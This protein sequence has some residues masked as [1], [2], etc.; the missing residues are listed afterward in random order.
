MRLTHPKGIAGEEKA[1]RYLKKHHWNI[2]KR[3]WHCRFGEIDIIASKN[4]LLVFFEVRYRSSSTF[5]GAAESITLSKLEKL[6]K[7]VNFYLTMYPTEQ[8]VRLDALLL[9]DGLLQR[10]RHIANI[11]EN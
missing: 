1:C 9:E 5:G 11:S 4:N 2:I 8:L 3:N 10:V 7:S 6:K